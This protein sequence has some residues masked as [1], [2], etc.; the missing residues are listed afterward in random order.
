[1]LD[2]FEQD[3]MDVETRWEQRKKQEYVREDEISIQSYNAFLGGIFIYG[4]LV[5]ACTCVSLGNKIVHYSPVLLL[6]IYLVCLFLGKKISVI[7]SNPLVTFLGYNLV[8][9]PL[10]LIIAAILYGGMGSDFRDVIA[11]TVLITAGIIACVTIISVIIPEWLLDYGMTALALVGSMVTTELVI[12]AFGLPQSGPAWAFAFLLGMRITNHYRKA[13]T[14][15][16]TLSNAVNGA[17]DV[18][19][20]IINIFVLIAQIMSLFSRNDGSGANG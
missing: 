7:S 19:L 14:F 16:K 4:L 17:L 10:G 15:Q 11:Q 18:Y 1:M 2:Q 8:T 13:Q 20:D 3:A 5:D 6:V 9:A 12:L